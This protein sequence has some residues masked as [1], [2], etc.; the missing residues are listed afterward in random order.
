MD[1]DVNTE[2]DTEVPQSP[3]VT[4]LPIPG[5]DA[6]TALPISVSEIPVVGRD[7]VE[8]EEALKRAKSALDGKH[9]DVAIE[10]DADQ[11]TPRLD[12]SAT[13]PSSVSA[14]HVEL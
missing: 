12:T 13:T 4:I 10:D 5:H 7:K 14:L 1:G 6:N 2:Y 11:L 3:E 9:E 8:I